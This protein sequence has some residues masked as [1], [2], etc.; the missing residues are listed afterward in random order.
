MWIK[1][2]WFKIRFVK[3]II[4]LSVLVDLPY[5]HILLGNIYCTQ[6]CIT[7]AVWTHNK[8]CSVTNTHFSTYTITVSLHTTMYIGLVGSLWS[9]DIISLFF[10]HIIIFSFGVQN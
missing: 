5:L 8:I 7:S 2:S 1:N 4:T 3:I 6:I 10:T 9:R